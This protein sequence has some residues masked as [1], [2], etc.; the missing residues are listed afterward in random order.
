MKNLKLVSLI[1]L[2]AGMRLSAQHEQIY[3]PDPDPL[4][5]KRIDQWQDFKSGHES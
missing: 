4:I 2:L 3:V 5:Q 1:V